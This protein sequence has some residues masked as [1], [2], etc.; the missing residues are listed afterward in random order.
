MDANLFVTPPANN[1]L[2]PLWIWSGSAE[3]AEIVRQVREM[4]E[5]G[6]GGVCI[7]PG[8]GLKLPCLS[9]AWFD[10]VA[11]AAEAGAAQGLEV[12][13]NG[14]YPH[15]GGVMA[16]RVTLGRPELRE[17][18]L[19]FKETIVQGGQQV[20][21]G[22]P[23]ATVLNALAVPLKR[24]R[25]LWEDAEN[26]G[27]YI[28][29]HRGGTDDDGSSSGHRLYWKA[30]AGRWRV[31]VF[32]QTTPVGD[33]SVPR[34]DPLNP[35][36]V[37]RFVEL[38]LAPF[39]D[40]LKNLLGDAVPGVLAAEPEARE[41]G[42][43][44]SDVLQ[45]TFQDRNGYDLVRCLP[46]L[47][48]HF[49]ANTARIRYDYFQ[50]LCEML[51]GNY[52]GP[53]AAW[54]EGQG[55]AYAADA[56]VLRNARRKGID[57]AGTS[58]SVQGRGSEEASV[59]RR[60]AFR[61]NPRFAAS[62]ANQDGKNR[63][64]NTCFHSA[65]WTLTMARMKAEL[66]GVAA[67]GCN[68]YSPHGMHFSLDG[69][70][71]PGDRPSLFH[72][73][74]YWKHFRLLADYSARLSYAMSQGQRVANVAVLDPVTTLWTHLGHPDQD[75]R[76]VGS[77]PEEE[78]LVTRLVSDW[79]YISETLVRTQR[80]HDHLDPEALAGA[81]V[82]GGRLKVGSAS[83]NVLIIPP[84][85]NLEFAA[86]ERLREFVNNGGQV[87]CLGLLPVE[88]IQEG[89]SVVDAL[90]RLTDMEPGRM[91]KDY[92]GHEFG[93]H[94]LQRGNLYLIRTGGSVERNNGGRALVDLLDRILPRPVLVEADRDMADMVRV[95]Q[96]LDGK[97][98]IC[99]LANT[100]D[101][102]F[103]AR[104][105]IQVPQRHRRAE[106]WDLETGRRTALDSVTEDGR[107]AVSVS[108]APNQSQ[109]LVLTEGRGKVPEV[110][111]EPDLVLETGGNWKVDLEEDN[112]LRLDRFRMQVDLQSRGTKQGWHKA[113]YKDNRWPVVSPG[114]F[115][116][117]VGGLS[118][119]PD[120]P[121]QIPESNAGLPGLRL[122]IVCWFRA[123]FSADIVPGKLAL[124]MDRGAIRGEYQVYLNG[125][126]LPGNAFRP[127]FRYDHGNVTC[128][129][130]RRVTKGRNVIAV[131]VEIATLSDGI[132]DALYLFGRMGVASWRSEFLRITP[133]QERGPVGQPDG[134]RTPFYAGT[135][136]HTR[137]VTL[138]KPTTRRFG[139][140]LAGALSGRDDVVEVLVN[141]HS[142]GV[143]AWE[144][145]RW[146]GQTEWLKPG[147]N[148][149]TLR[150]TNT[151]S[152]LLT[153]HDYDS[154]SGRLAP[155][156]V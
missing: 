133:M 6:I 52:H 26:L 114:S 90:S 108:F 68:L 42:L 33:T 55:L 43:P 104:V 100:S 145:Y 67:S 7:V 95:H 117:Q 31:L 150:V 39:A 22:L 15:Q 65:D 59:D 128:A 142:L 119:Q 20:D 9:Q 120:L 134:L 106:H 136:A 81:S 34:F 62:V 64:F 5:K 155:V 82:S 129:I 109:L 149:I 40:R 8:G 29:Y 44:W 37:S 124:V 88:D 92:V 60:V 16:E 151:L 87:V 127:T 77:D 13:L 51:E 49:G 32:L 19:T 11:L 21:M 3:E 74:P 47:I 61:G 156:S 17:Q 153:G 70:R 45:D 105:A 63:T 10:R 24:D 38:C 83:Y 115:I 143:R 27:K 130:G 14:E 86:F 140:V 18:Q 96:R 84:I 139:L 131:R 30:P 54:C 79:A 93:V 121:L 107:L 118:P 103:D 53:I 50:T 137:D 2:L 110:D 146:T 132:L 122:P 102:A 135:V 58:A 76:Y 36:A 99:F 28:G 1:R 56:P 141:G 23:L 94:V 112:A 73:N 41:A 123:T 144:P 113:D 91:I 152:R 101:R 69:I 66:D 4:A 72:Q 148:R 85:T 154:K 125:S 46:A 71:K 126:R 48:T 116:G 25:C 111:P 98:R 35:A 89:P 12:W 57:I 78:K 97:D 75:W 147:K 80:D 138:K